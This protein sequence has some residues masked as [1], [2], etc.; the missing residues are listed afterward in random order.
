MEHKRFIFNE[1]N[2]HDMA[3]ELSEVDSRDEMVSLSID[4]IH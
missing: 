1:T 3:Q 2:F 4:D